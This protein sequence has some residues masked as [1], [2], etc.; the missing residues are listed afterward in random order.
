V[1]ARIHERVANKRHN[2]AHQESRKVVNKYGVIAIENL[3]I[4]G[5]VKN[6]CLAKSISDAAWSRFF[7]CLFYK[8]ANADRKITEVAAAHTS[9]D[10]VRPVYPKWNFQGWVT[11]HYSMMI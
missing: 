8:A 11:N 2:F 3:N 5:M 1:V 10:C 6:H 9:T 7:G 4:K